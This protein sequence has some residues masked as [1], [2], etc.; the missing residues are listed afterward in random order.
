[1]P[2]AQSICPPPASLTRHSALM[3]FNAAAVAAHFSDCKLE[4]GG[5]KLAFDA[6]P[7]PVTL[8]VGN[9][10]SDDDVKLRADMEQY[11]KLERC[12]VMR[13]GDGVSKG[14]AFV[15]FSLPDA[16]TRAKDAIEEQFR[17]EFNEAQAKRV[18]ISK[19]KAEMRQQQQQAIAAAAAEQQR[20][21]LIAAATGMNVSA[22]HRALIAA[23]TGVE[24]SAVPEPAPA[25]EATV[26]EATVAAEADGQAED[27]S[28]KED[29]AP[30]KVVRSEHMLDRTVASLFSKCLYIS[31][32][33]QVRAC[34]AVWYCFHS[35]EI[36]CLGG[37]LC[38]LHN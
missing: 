5:E 8:F 15:E 27:A 26:T 9:M 16:A 38:P 18:S 12:F 10:S 34:I 1:M 24:V 25:V 31:N 3:P 23:A 4:L 29:D 14:Y 30:V 37:R 36:D 21:A 17:K 7:L 28:Q 11:G 13:S 33:P 22:Q 19:I 32:L 2:L 20:Q 35:R 6:P